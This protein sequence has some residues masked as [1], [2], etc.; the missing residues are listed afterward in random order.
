MS[1]NTMFRFNTLSIFTKRKS[2]LVYVIKI[3]VLAVKD[4][5]KIE[6]LHFRY[7]V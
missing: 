4:I 7:S 5:F 2:Y 6:L 1:K 3:N